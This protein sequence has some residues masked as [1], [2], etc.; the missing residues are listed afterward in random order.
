MLNLDKVLIDYNTTLSAPEIV[1]IVTKT[2]FFTH[3]IQVYN[4]KAEVPMQKFW[5]KIEKVRIFEI[6]KNSKLLIFAVSNTASNL[7][8]HIKTIDDYMFNYVNDKIIK[9]TKSNDGSNKL[10]KIVS[11][12]SITKSEGNILLWE[13]FYDIDTQFFDDD[14]ELM[15]PN[16]LRNI[17]DIDVFVELNRVI[18]DSTNVCCKWK[19]VQLK[20][21]NYVNKSICFFKKNEQQKNIVHVQYTQQPIINMQPVIQPP[22]LKPPVIQL[23]VI[24]A[25]TIQSG[26]CRISN[27]VLLKEITEK[28]NQLKKV[29]PVD[30]S[31][32]LPKLTPQPIQ[33]QITKTELEINL[34]KKIKKRNVISKKVLESNK[35][36]IQKDNE[37]KNKYESLLLSLSKKHLLSK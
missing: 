23:P 12:N 32:P 34:N 33:P 20:K 18:F 22:T 4:S 19:I 15:N 13:M 9:D 25:P 30:K 35:E 1:A 26:P 16:S 28:M 6:K 24:Q 3:D 17:D 7:V 36:M 10:K 14:N 37:E 2:N 8:S 21:T 11:K 5:Y 29:T 27:D 31:Q